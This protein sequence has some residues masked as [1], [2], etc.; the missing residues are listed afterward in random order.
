MRSI[1]VLI[2]S[3]RW[4]IEDIDVKTVFLQGKQI[5]RTAYLQPPKEANTIKIWK[6]QKCVYDL[7]DASRY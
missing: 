1:F 5:E 2:G 6:L 4:E 3:N 7:T